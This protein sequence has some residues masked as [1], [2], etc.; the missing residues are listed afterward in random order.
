M[1]RSTIAI[2][3]IIKSEVFSPLCSCSTRYFLVG[4]ELFLVTYFSVCRSW[5][6]LATKIG[7]YFFKAYVSQVDQNNW[8]VKRNSV[9]EILVT[10]P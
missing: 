1:I 2:S 6:E 10:S 7:A 3:G 8:H 9:F 4:R 5:C